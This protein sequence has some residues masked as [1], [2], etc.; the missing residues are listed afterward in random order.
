MGRPTRSLA[1]AIV[2]AA[3]LLGAGC[4]GDTAEENAYVEAVNR[5]QTEFAQTFERLRDDI[6]ATSTP[7]QDQR[8]LGRFRAAVDDAVGELRRIEP[9]EAVASL[10]RRLVGDIGRYG[11]EIEKARTAFGSTDPQKVLQAQTRLVARVSRISG[12]INAVI[13]DINQELRG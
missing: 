11:T 7:A 10:H 4:G 5:T 3:V 8:T 1:A 9:P 13:T 2:S 6:T 12:D